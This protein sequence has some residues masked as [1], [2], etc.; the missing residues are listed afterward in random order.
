MA[1]I[2]SLESEREEYGQQS[3][4]LLPREGE[5]QKSIAYGDSRRVR[6]GWS[7]SEIIE[8]SEEAAGSRAWMV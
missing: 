4:R 8:D 5:Y 3:S 7:Q 6:N 1:K 2:E